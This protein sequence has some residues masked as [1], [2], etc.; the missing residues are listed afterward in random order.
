MTVKCPFLYQMRDT[1][2]F[3]HYVLHRQKYLAVC[4]RDL[5]EVHSLFAKPRYRYDKDVGL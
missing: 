4:K 1:G 3:Q 5:E 2:S